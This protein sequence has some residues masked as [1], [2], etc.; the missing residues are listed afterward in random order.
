MNDQKEDSS[1]PRPLKRQR[2]ALEAI[3][4]DDVEISCR[5]FTLNNIQQPV[6]VPEEVVVGIVLSN[7][8]KQAG[9]ISQRAYDALTIVLQYWMVPD[10]GWYIHKLG[11]RQDELKEDL[12]ERIIEYKEPK[13][14]S[15]SYK[16]KRNLS[17][18]QKHEYSEMI[19]VP[20]GDDDMVNDM[21]DRLTELDLSALLPEHQI[22][23]I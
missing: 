16:G 12:L 22:S 19:E 20:I 14:S 11:S 1:P 23:V 18:E 15:K 7:G 8:G 3:D 5:D 2:Y 6:E 13:T 9:E 21:L 17:A 4:E 10:L